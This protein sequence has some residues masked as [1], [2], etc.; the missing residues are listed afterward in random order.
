[1]ILPFPRV[2][3]VVRKSR[4]H[5]SNER[6]KEGYECGAPTLGRFIALAGKN[7]AGL[8]NDFGGAAP[9]PN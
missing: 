9:V 5:F 1:V 4:F 3:E 8:L 7:R 6:R 2:V